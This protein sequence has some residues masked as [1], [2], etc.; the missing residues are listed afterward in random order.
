MP[1]QEAGRG[2]ARAAA[3]SPGPHAAP[4]RASA[5]VP[6]AAR[7]PLPA[8]GSAPA[9]LPARTRVALLVGRAALAVL[10]LM[11]RGATTLPGRL[12]LRLDARLPARL[13]AGL[14]D[15][16]AL[17]TGT[18]GKTTTAAMLAGALRGAGRRL[19]HN[20]GGANLR[21]GIA[22]AL[23][24][25]PPGARA[26]LL[27]VDEATMPY[28]GT[29]Q[30]RVAVVTN[31]FRDQLDRYG[32]LE[33]ARALVARGLA[34]M[35][36]GAVAVLNADDPLVATL[37]ADGRPRAVYFGVGPAV[38]AAS[39]P[40]V[41]AA[42]EGCRGPTD[43][44]DDG[45]GPPSDAPRC[46]LCG[47]ELRYAVRLHAHVGLWRCDGCGRARPDPEVEVTAWSPGAPDRPGQLGLRTPDGP[48]AFPLRL[49]GLYNAYNVAAAVAAALA[50]GLDATTVARALGEFHHAFGRMEW[51]VL[52]G[53]RTCLALVKNPVGC[54]LALR[55]ALDDPH[56]GKALA[57]ALNDGLADGTDVSWIWDADFE[58]LAAAQQGFA[59]VVAAGSRAEDMALRLKYAGVDGS[60]VRLIGDPLRAALAAAAAAGPDATVY[61]L[62]TYTAMLRLRAALARRGLLPPFWEA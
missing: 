61:L 48:L 37:A 14:P 3:G 30:P 52:G 58:A 22:T 46:P 55:T 33:T 56:P 47:G 5:A 32:E 53:H 62:P 60:R 16:T 20:R 54:T 7:L 4:R 10:R 24:A 38:A 26:A 1:E 51:T 12:A 18:N 25:A 34:A 17:V 19:A 39:P 28:A 8:R 21:T 40:T 35:P 44:G 57:L 31:F 27:E 13:A 23:I 41:G 2:A 45:A 15:G 6:S 11:G 59:A 36:D 50:L 43:A 9:P 49:P 42:R 29:L